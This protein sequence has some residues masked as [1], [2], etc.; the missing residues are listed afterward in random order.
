M[1]NGLKINTTGGAITEADLGRTLMHE[2]VLAGYPGWYMDTRLPPFRRAYISAYGEGWAPLFVFES[3]SRQV[4]VYRLQ[5]QSGGVK[6]AK[7]ELIELKSFAELPA[8]P[9]GP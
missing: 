7:F 4:A 9:T 3:S 6:T 8:L 5:I 2:H 1:G